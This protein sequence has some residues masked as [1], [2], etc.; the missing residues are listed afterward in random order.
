MMLHQRYGEVLDALNAV[1][2][3]NGGTLWADEYMNRYLTTYRASIA[4]F[5]IA[6]K[7]YMTITFLRAQLVFFFWDCVG[8]ANI[9]KDGGHHRP[10]WAAPCLIDNPIFSNNSEEE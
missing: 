6:D 5:D 7:D 9:D 3:H 2:D 4:L 1:I 8:E 10:Y